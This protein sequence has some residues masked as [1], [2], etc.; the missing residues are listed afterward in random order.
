MF[1]QDDP[2]IDDVFFE[3]TG[4]T[5]TNDIVILEETGV[6]NRSTIDL[7]VNVICAVGYN[8]TDCNTFCEEINGTLMCR[9]DE[10]HPPNNTSGGPH[11]HH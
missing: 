9:E 3:F 11:C 10:N 6:F 7:S 1:D 5:A 8:G 2:L 4:V